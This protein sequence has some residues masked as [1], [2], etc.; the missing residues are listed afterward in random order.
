[1]PRLYQASA[2]ALSPRACPRFASAILSETKVGG[3]GLLVADGI[4]LEN[5]LAALLRTTEG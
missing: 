3:L 4:R 2:T 1:M 5:D